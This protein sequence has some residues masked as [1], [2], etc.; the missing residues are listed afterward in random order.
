MIKNWDNYYKLLQKY[1]SKFN[2]LPGSNCE[3]ENIKL[4][5]WVGRQRSSYNKH[6]LSSD[7][8][9]KL[10]EISIWVWKIV[11]KDYKQIFISNKNKLEKLY[12]QNGIIV[13]SYKWL[14][15]NNYKKL[16]NSIVIGPCKN[17]SKYK[18]TLED[19][20]KE[21]G[22]HKEWMDQRHTLIVGDNQKWTPNYFDLITRQLIEKYGYVPCAEF[23]R[24]NGYGSYTSYMYSNNISMEDLQKKYNF[25][26]CKWISKNDM[27]WLS[28]AE[29]C[30][31]NFLYSRGIDIKKGKRYPNSYSDETGRKYG[32]YDLHF[33]AKI[34]Q[35]TDKWINVEVWGDKPN[36]HDE[37]NYSE[38]RKQK[39]EFNKNDKYFLGI[40]YNSCYKENKLESILKKYIGVIKSFIF[41]DE[42]DKLFNSTQWTKLDI[43][44]KECKYI[45][46]HNNNILPT[47]GW[48]RKKK[49]G[50]YENREDNEWEQGIKIELNTLRHYIQDCGGFRKIR[51]IL[52]TSNKSTMKWNK[53]KLINEIKK[54][55]DIYKLPVS[56][57]R[58]RLRRKL[59]KSKYEIELMKKCA[60]I[61]NSCKNHFKNGYQESLN[62]ANIKK[63]EI[64]M[65]EHFK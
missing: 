36:G 43:V 35:F 57:I 12:Q 49:D 33:K 6:T 52:K 2:K 14:C 58:S 7:R 28:H 20:S 42:R 45:M 22:I 16:Y 40:H 3:Y 63:E 34:E 38:K 24:V 62:E 32:L 5:P 10:N 18:I 1:I 31:A 4:G 60:S 64:Y 54:I 21:W 61:E 55:Y 9:N 17:D 51:D 13:L 15:N 59:N 46:E 37:K 11:K 39:E 30:L 48:F 19:L 44:L 56:T 26:K 8:I 47:E 65:L 29:C 23:L 27:Y 53:E 50:K 41:K 25:N